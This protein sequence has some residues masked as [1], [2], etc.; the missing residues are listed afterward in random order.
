MLGA[1]GVGAIVAKVMEAAWLSKV[2]ER[3]A[4]KS[5]LRDRRLEAYSAAAQEFLSFGLT[6][7]K[8]DDPFEAYS[9]IARAMLLVDDEALAKRMDQFIAQVDRLRTQQHG[10]QLYAALVAEA[11]EI[12]SKMRE[13]LVR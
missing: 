5:W 7:P 4:L 8:P 10:E 13:A 6:R 12:V 11:R 2:T 9:S 1:V 3:A